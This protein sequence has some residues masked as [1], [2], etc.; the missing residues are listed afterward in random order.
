MRDAQ[1]QVDDL[2]VEQTKVDA[3]VEQV[4]TRRRTATGTGWT[5]A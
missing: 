1:I 4:K 3:D 5:R 2:T